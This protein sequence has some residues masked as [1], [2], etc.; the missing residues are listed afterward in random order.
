MDLTHATINK[1][2]AAD[3]LGTFS[4]ADTVTV[5]WEHVKM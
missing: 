1:S 2:A 5:E 4:M 3:P